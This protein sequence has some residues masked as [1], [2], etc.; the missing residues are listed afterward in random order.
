[1]APLVFYLSISIL[2]FFLSIFSSIAYFVFC[3]FHCHWPHVLQDSRQH[4][5]SAPQGCLLILCTS[6]YDHLPLAHSSSAAVFKTE[7]LFR[8]GRSL[9]TCICTSELVA[10][11]CTPRGQG[12][13]ILQ[14][15]SVSFLSWHYE[16]RSRCEPCGT[17]LVSAPGETSSQERRVGGPFSMDLLPVHC[18]IAPSLFIVHLTSR[19][20]IAIL[21]SSPFLICMH[22]L[23]VCSLPKQSHVIVCSDGLVCDVSIYHVPVFFVQSYSTLWCRSWVL[24]SG[25][26][27]LIW[28]SRCIIGLQAWEQGCLS[29]LQY[30]TFDPCKQLWC[31]HPDN[32]FFCKTKKG[33]P[34]DGTMCAPGKVPPTPTTEAEDETCS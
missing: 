31:S 3:Y 33:P 6:Y 30:R 2:L 24:H 23:P 10:C 11:R 28:V 29:S 4:F 15:L 5:C 22:W 8:H 18:F 16:W 26:A 13:G 9:H 17:P 7:L 12:F 27:V 25:G 20:S 1:M 14:F 19:I 32:P 34:I 21:E